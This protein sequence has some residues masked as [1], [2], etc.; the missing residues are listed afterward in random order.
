M[1]EQIPILKKNLMKHSSVG[2]DV[3]AEVNGLVDHC[4]DCYL[5]WNPDIAYLSVGFELND[6]QA[7]FVMF[8][9]TVHRHLLFPTEI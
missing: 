5:S 6:L 7:G 9:C 8:Q 2:F 4:W 1:E 3:H